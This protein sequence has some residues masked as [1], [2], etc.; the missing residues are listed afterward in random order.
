MT[1]DTRNVFSASM[2]VTMWNKG[3][4]GEKADM[5]LIRNNFNICKWVAAVGICHIYCIHCI[6]VVGATQNEGVLVNSERARFNVATFTAYPRMHSAYKT[7]VCNFSWPLVP[8]IIYGKVIFS[9]AKCHMWLELFTDEELVWLFH[10][11]RVACAVGLYAAVKY[12]SFVP[13]AVCV[14]ES[15]ITARCRTWRHF[16]GIITLLRWTLFW[17]WTVRLSRLRHSGRA[18]Q[19]SWSRRTIPNEHG[20]RQDCGYWLQQNDVNMTSLDRPAWGHVCWGRS[21]SQ[22]TASN[23]SAVMIGRK[24]SREYLIYKSMRYGQ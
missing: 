15:H 13:A 10:M 19:R 14:R 23:A 9:R 18:S 16:L 6:T 7:F 11:L 5:N 1:W 8:L 20:R 12:C 24:Q 3:T 22:S 2:H 21:A 4:V 17:Q